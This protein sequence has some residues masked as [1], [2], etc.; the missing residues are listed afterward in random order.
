MRLVFMGTGPFAVPT[1]E[2]LLASEHTVAA[3]VT[4]PARPGKGRHEPPT[5]PMREVAVRHGLSVFAPES[6]NSTEAHGQLAALAADLFVV[7]DYGQILARETL[8]LARLGGINL[9]GSL[10]PKYRGAAPV[11]WAIYHGETETGVSVLHMTPRLDAGPLLAVAKT[12][13]GPEETTADVEQR[14]SQLGV[15]P[16][17]ESIALLET[18]D[19][20]N[21]IGTPQDPTLATR[22]PRLKKTDGAVDWSRSAEQI[23]NQ[24]RA[25]HPWPGTYTHWRRPG[26]EPL[27][28]I[29]DRVSVVAASIPLGT[30]GEVVHTDGKSLWIATGSTPLSL[31]RVQ[32]AGKR[33]MEIAE[34]LRG[35]TVRVGAKFGEEGAPG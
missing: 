28:L 4:R 27:R 31:D 7:C 2:R 23:K 24:V 34:F 5:S 17:L 25:F 33:V 10:L 12:P 1:C 13:I 3:L 11:H 6:V 20:V 26:H 29:L 9:H 35:H 16:V 18:W 19:G 15:E 30:P 8:A 32:P 22:A 21:S 14:L